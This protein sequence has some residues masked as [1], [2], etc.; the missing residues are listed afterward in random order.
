M[1]PTTETEMA[2]FMFYVWGI[3]GLLLNLLAT[4]ALLAPSSVGVGTSAYTS[5]LTLIWIGGM[6]F[7]AAAHM[8]RASPTAAN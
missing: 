2:K 5:A 6:V 8:M 4:L 3:I 1:I 7:F